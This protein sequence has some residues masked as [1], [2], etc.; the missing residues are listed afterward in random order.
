[1]SNSKVFPARRITP[2]I[3]QIR[4][5]YRESAQVPGA[6]EQVVV[7][8]ATLEVLYSA[9]LELERNTPSL[10]VGLHSHGEGVSAY[11][12]AVD[13]FIPFGKDDFQQYLEDLFEPSKDEYLDVE[14]SVEAIEIRAL[15]AYQS[16][17]AEP[18]SVVQA[19]QTRGTIEVREDS[20][21]AGRFLYFLGGEGS[22]VSYDDP[23]EARGEALAVALAR[24]QEHQDIGVSAW[25]SMSEQQK[26]EAIKAT[27]SEDEEKQE[28]QRFL[29]HYKCPNCS[30]EWDDEWDCQVD[31]DCGECGARHISPYA[32]EDA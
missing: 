15:D 2:I 3:E 8:K 24:V 11:A 29:N 17:A 1:M 5:L 6:E 27:F 12:F 7:D 30:S 23:S 14:T 25:G 18:A 20:D 9:A 28:A 32:S 13:P 26:L 21:Q 10:C 19:L 31:D 22:D 4:E 16:A